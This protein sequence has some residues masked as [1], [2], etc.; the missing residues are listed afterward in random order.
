[1]NAQFQKLH[2]YKITRKDLNPP[3]AFLK[4][5]PK[6]ILQVNKGLQPSAPRCAKL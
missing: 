6:H 4:F 2:P 5:T 3:Q 1:M